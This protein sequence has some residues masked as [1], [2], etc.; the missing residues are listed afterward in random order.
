MYYVS[1]RKTS[2]LSLKRRFPWSFTVYWRRKRVWRWPRHWQTFT[3]VG[4]NLFSLRASLFTYQ[5]GQSFF[6]ALER[7]KRKNFQRSTFHERLK[8]L[9][10]GWQ[11]VGRANFIAQ[12]KAKEKKNRIMNLSFTNNLWHHFISLIV[13][14]LRLFVYNERWEAVHVPYT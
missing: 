1:R 13:I 6:L 7:C 3:D 5:S 10:F 4:H 14:Y 11:R 12:S 8:F 2:W 9:L